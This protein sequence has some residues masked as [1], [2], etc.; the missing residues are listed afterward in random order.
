MIAT[1][2]QRLRNLDTL[3]GLQT[4][5]DKEAQRMSEVPPQY[6]KYHKL[7]SDHFEEGLPQH[8]EWDHEIVLME[9][10]TPRFHKIYNLNETELKELRAY[11]EDK[12]QKGYIRRSKSSA[13][14]PI[15]FVPKKNGKL[16]LVI[17]YRQL[18]SITVKDKIPLPLITE[19]KNRLYGTK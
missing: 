7:F 18:N 14:Y 3:L 8:T 1:I 19:I 12:L 9:G 10:K 15:M 11:L 13:G 2:R 16:R 5:E 6:Q 4:K 17:D